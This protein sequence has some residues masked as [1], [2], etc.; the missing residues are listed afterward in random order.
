MSQECDQKDE[1]EFPHSIYLCFQPDRYLIFQ[2]M[3]GL[4]AINSC[5]RNCSVCLMQLL[6]TERANS[7][8]DLLNL[9]ENVSELQHSLQSDQQAAEGKLLVSLLSCFYF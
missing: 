6:S 2:K 7:S 5:F 1:V 9:Q 8:R 4:I 3:C